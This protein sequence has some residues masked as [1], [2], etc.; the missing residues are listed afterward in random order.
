[1]REAVGSRAGRP[2]SRNV[3]ASVPGSGAGL[4]GWHG[5][6][7]SVRGFGRLGASARS[8]A[9]AFL[10]AAWEREGRGKE[11]EREEGAGGSHAQEREKRGRGR[12]A[13]RLGSDSGL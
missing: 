7:L 9:N 2:V 4:A 1:V 12:T 11:R 5:C 3:E 10:A 13:R 8:L 6:D